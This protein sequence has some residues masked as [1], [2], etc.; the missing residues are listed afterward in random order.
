MKSF[1]ELLRKAEK[2]D[3]ARVAELVSKSP[4]LVRMVVKGER[5]DYYNIQKVMSDMLE[6]RERLA[7]REERRRIR[8]AERETKQLAA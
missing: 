4:S 1:K 2:G 7:D 5:A 8:K 6:A 3:Y